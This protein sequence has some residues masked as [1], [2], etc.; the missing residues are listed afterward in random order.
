MALPQPA[1]H[2][3]DGGAAGGQQAALDLDLR[4]ARIGC[5]HD[6]IRR[7]H[8]L[9]AEGEADALNGEHDWL[10][11][12]RR[13]RAEGIDFVIFDQQGVAAEM[14]RN[15]RQIEPGREIG[16]FGKHHGAARPG[17]AFITGVGLCHAAQHDWRKS[18]QLRGTIDSD[19]EQAVAQLRRNAAVGR[20]RLVAV[21]DHDWLRLNPTYLRPKNVNSA[22]RQNAMPSSSTRCTKN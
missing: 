15:F 18:V 3:T 4:E 2:H 1:R 11:A 9:D 20:I 16:A 14:G 19:Q 6:Q 10:A 5:G 17:L 12:P 21:C 7:Q 22:P 13:A 8:H